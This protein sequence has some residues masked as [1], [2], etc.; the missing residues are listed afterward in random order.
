[1]TLN[2]RQKVYSVC[3]LVYILTKMSKSCIM[4]MQKV[5]HCLLKECLCLQQ[6]VTLLSC[7]CHIFDTFCYN[8]QLSLC[9]KIFSSNIDT[10]YI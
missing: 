10:C 5:L 2:S 7:F 8:S 3:F 9:I 4:L 1:M 6:K